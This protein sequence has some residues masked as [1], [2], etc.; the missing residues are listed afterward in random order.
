MQS[1]TSN[2]VFMKHAF[3]FLLDSTPIFRLKDVWCCEPDSFGETKRRTERGERE[4]LKAML[5]SARWPSAAEG[6]ENIERG[7]AQLLR[8]ARVSSAIALS[9]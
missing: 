4:K 9:C 6:D 5:P 2:N 7:G 3:I 1:L 8:M